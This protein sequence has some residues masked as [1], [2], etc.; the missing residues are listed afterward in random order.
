MAFRKLCGQFAAS[1]ALLG[2]VLSGFAPLAAT[3]ASAAV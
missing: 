1:L 2:M 3:T